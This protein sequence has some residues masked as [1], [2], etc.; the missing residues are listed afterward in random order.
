MIVNRWFSVRLLVVT[1]ESRIT[2]NSK[3]LSVVI[4]MAWLMI[5]ARFKVPGIVLLTILVSLSQS[6]YADPVYSGSCASIDY[7]EKCCPPGESCKAMDGNCYCNADC[8]D[9]NDCCDDIFCQPSS[10][11]FYRMF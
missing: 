6:Q 9:D 8:H 11:N 2:L 10:N 7:S 4:Y 3:L 5:T 1:E